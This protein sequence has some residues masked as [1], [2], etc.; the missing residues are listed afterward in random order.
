MESILVAKAPLHLGGEKC[1]RSRRLLSRI[2][3]RQVYPAEQ[4]RR[5]EVAPAGFGQVPNSKE[6]QRGSRNGAF[7]KAP[8]APLS[9]AIRALPTPT[10]GGASIC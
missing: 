7:P 10:I 1:V 8:G 9:A 5:A 2:A 3:E 4:T 6:W